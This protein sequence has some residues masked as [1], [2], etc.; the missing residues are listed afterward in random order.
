MKQPRRE[1]RLLI[2]REPA[3]PRSFLEATRVLD[4]ARKNRLEPVF[5]EKLSFREQVD[6]FASARL[7]IAGHGSG[8]TNLLFSSPDCEVFEIF[9]RWHGI[10]PDF[11]QI[12][13]QTCAAYAWSVE[14]V[15]SDGRI[16]FPFW[17]VE[18]FLDGGYPKTEWSTSESVK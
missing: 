4:F 9:S 14:P 5:L 8:L 1:K 15:G 10:R 2:L 3:L 6:A 7:V 12:A 17:K 11:F 18:A 13:R 16:P